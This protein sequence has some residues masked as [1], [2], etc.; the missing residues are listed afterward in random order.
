MASG[1]LA[2]Q[3]L[4]AVARGGRLDLHLGGLPAFVVA[5]QRGPFN[6]FAPV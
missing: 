1:S 5:L 3:R 6:R 4:R 2:W